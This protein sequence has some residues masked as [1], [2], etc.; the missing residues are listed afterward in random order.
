MH[1][2]PLFKYTDTAHEY[3]DRDRDRETTKQQAPADR[4]NT[5][6]HRG[7]LPYAGYILENGKTG[8]NFGKRTSMSLSQSEA[9]S[10]S[11]AGVHIE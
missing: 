2:C 7:Q 1:R 3:M 5:R 8:Q 6:I 9:G 4:Y 10:K 11:N